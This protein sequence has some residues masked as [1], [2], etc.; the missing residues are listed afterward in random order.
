MKLTVTTFVSVDG[1]AQGPGGP[2]EDLSGGFTR[3]GWVVPLFDEDTGEFIDEVFAL[4]DAFLLGRKTFDIFA[5]SWPNSTDPE[6]P[7]AHA[8]NTLPKYVASRTLTEPAWGPT[9]VLDHDI[10]SAVAALKKQP[11]RE[12]QVHGSIEL[13]RVLH[14]HDL[15]DEYRLLTFPVVVGQG[16]RLF[17]Q[18]LD[19]ALTLVESRTTKSGVTICSYVPA[20]RPEYGLAEVE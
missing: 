8:L 16:R 13:V 19:T 5:A 7:V 1:V 4:V 10:P 17:D 3:G 15:V 9:T 14:D 11:G 2:E 20:G 6:D 18:G 12:L